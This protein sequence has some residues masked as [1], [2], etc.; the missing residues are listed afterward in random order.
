MN[1]NMPNGEVNLGGVN[2]NM[3]GNAGNELPAKVS[4][5]TKIKDFLFQDVENMELV[6]TPREQKFIDFWTQE[7][8]IDKAYN[9]LFQEIKFK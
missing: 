1:E 5:W 7:V 4:I 2:A 3:A 8:T 9:F 6:L